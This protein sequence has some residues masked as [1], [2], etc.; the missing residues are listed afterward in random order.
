MGRPRSFDY[1]EAKRLRKLGLS[2]DE[3][4]VRLGVSTNAVARACDPAFRRRQD[5][6]SKRAIEELRHPCFGGCGVLVWGHVAGSGYCRACF[7]ERFQR[8]EVHGTECEYVTHGC[9]CGECTRAATE[10][11]RMRR[12]RSRVPCSHGCGRMVDGINRRT[13]NK[14]PECQS[15]ATKRVHAERRARKSADVH[16]PSGAPAGLRE[17]TVAGGGLGA[18][19]RAVRTGT[20]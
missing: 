10:A 17:Q 19:S 12:E 16:Q 11:K 18:A 6:L 13:P 2:Y 20:A 15:C 1:D 3:I 8:R 4:G 5:A 9:R 14:P 7:A